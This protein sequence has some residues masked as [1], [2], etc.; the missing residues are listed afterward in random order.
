[1][2]HFCIVKY[3]VSCHIYSFKYTSIYKSMGTNMSLNNL[4]EVHNLLA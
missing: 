2:L 4:N 3:L 1:L